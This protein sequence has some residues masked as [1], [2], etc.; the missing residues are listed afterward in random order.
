MAKLTEI[1]KQ[2]EIHF[3]PMA[4]DRVI[5]KIIPHI[6]KRGYLI[7]NF[8]GDIEID[9]EMVET[10]SNALQDMYGTGLPKNS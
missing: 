9:E 8:K 6:K 10:I 7:H 5:L 1:E 2:I 3:S 4:W